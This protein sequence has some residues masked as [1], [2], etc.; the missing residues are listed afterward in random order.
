MV[1][2]V[3]TIIFMFLI[4]CTSTVFAGDI[5]E[6]LM[7]GEQKALFIGKLILTDEQKSIIMPLTIMMGSISQQEISVDSIDRYSGTDEVP[8][9]GD[10]IVVVLL[11]DNK[12][13]DSWIFKATSSDYKT[14]KLVSERDDM[15]KRYQEYINTGAY[16]EAQER[17]DAKKEI[18]T[19]T[20][21]IENIDEN[22]ESSE[23]R[24]AKDDSNNKT[25]YILIIS[26]VLFLLIV[27]FIFYKLLMTKE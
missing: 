5:P 17:L 9:A 4:V 18:S 23:Y 1:K 19:Q 25:N 27:V 14:L 22:K 10:F 16:F 8:I 26:S 11:S 13:Y 12:I 24:T 2:K 7:L 20:I 3:I 15:V 6:S 21:R